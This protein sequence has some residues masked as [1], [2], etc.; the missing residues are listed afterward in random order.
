M[1][2]SLEEEYCLE[3]GLESTGVGGGALQQDAGRSDHGQAA[4]ADL[5]QS[6]VLLRGSALAELKR[7]KAEEARRAVAALLALGHGHARD[8][9]RSRSD[10]TE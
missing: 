2:G 7:I 10:R 4:I 6:Q 9:C 3:D 8:H 1:G 5:L